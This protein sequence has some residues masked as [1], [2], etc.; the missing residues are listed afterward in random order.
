MP[1]VSKLVVQS[2]I[3]RP[4]EACPGVPGLSGRSLDKSLGNNKTSGRVL[5]SRHGRIG[6]W[7]SFIFADLFPS[8]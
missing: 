6:T 4:T 2:R 8:C 1:G 5:S 3:E 7:R